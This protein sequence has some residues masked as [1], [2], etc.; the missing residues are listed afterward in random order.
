MMMIR[1]IVPLLLIL[2]GLPWWCGCPATER[3]PSAAPVRD[4]TDERT[5]RSYLLYVPSTYSDK[6]AYPLVVACHGTWPYD[7]P[8]LQMREWASFAENQGIIVVAPLLAATKGDFPPPPD[9]QIALQGED[10]QAILA[11]VAALKRQYHIAEERVF[12]TGWSAGAYSMLHTGLRNPDIFRA[13]AIRQGSFDARFLDI[14]KDRLDR[15]QRIL[16][17]YGMTDF[18]RDQSKAMVTWLRDQKMYVDEEEIPGS[19]RRIDPK[20]AW[21][22]FCRVVKESPWVR[23]RSYETDP[24]DPRVIRFCLDAV[25]A[26][27]KVSWTF[28]EGQESSELSPVH[29][30]AEG[31]RYEIKAEVELQDRKKY[32]RKQVVQVS[33]Q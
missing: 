23:V 7:T 6:T 20:L 8:E 14:P 25:P 27:K 10:E 30:F 31:G 17:I 12:M 24:A 28:G 18:L 5:Q 13:F 29:T 11:I 16:V 22:Y 32:T 26:V 4:L 33:R 19:H 9:K 15:W 2:A 21:K 3:L 1:Q